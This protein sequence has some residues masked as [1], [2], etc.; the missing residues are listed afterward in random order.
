MNVARR[1]GGRQAAGAGAV[2]RAADHVLQQEGS[3]RGPAVCRAPLLQCGRI[4]TPPLFEGCWRALLGRRGDNRLGTDAERG[5][6]PC[7]ADEGG[8]TMGYALFAATIVR[9]NAAWKAVAFVNVN[10]HFE[11]S[12]PRSI[13]RLLEVL[14]REESG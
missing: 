13:G 8:W 1:D 5:Y 2:L 9:A 12:V 3:S 11:G 10:N 7:W 6:W 14:E 4:L